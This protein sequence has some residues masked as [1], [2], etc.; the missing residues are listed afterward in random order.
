MTP[1]V[2]WLTSPDFKASNPDSVVGWLN[3][4]FRF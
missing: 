3:T 4:T 1:G 2:I